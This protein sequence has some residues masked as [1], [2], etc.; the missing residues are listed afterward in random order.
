M[1]DSFTLYCLLEDQ[2]LKERMKR[3]KL[4]RK[5]DHIMED[6]VGNEN[7]MCKSKMGYECSIVHSS[8]MDSIAQITL[9]RF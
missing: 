7:F 3:G 4:K 2:V 9:D 8:Q 1:R 6:L 5:T